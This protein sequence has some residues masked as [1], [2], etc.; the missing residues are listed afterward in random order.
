MPRR[1]LR[2][3]VRSL[4]DLVVLGVALASMYYQGAPAWAFTLA[5]FI[6]TR[7][8]ILA[9]AMDLGALQRDIRRTRE[10]T[11]PAGG[12]PLP[13]TASRPPRPIPRGP[14]GKPLIPPF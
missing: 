14:D 5:V 10:E 8:S 9:T 2:V 13:P 3:Y 4:G 1:P 12:W 11:I 6:C 7:A